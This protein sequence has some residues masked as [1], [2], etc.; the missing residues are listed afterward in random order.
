MVFEITLSLVL[1]LSQ[2][3]HR[4]FKLFYTKNTLISKE[5]SFAGLTAKQETKRTTSVLVTPSAHDMEIAA[6]APPTSYRK[7]NVLEHLPSPA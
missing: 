1:V 6:V 5:I 4:K 7:N 2:S 3:S